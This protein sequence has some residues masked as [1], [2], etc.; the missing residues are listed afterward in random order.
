VTYKEITDKI[1]E[2]LQGDS[3]LSAEIKE[4]HFGRPLKPE[5]YPYC[6]V[7][8]DRSSIIFEAKNYTHEL[9][10]L[11]GVFDLNPKGDVAEKKVLDLS[12]RVR[13]VLRLNKLG[14]LVETSEVIA[15]ELFAFALKQ[16]ALS[17]VI[18]TYRCILFE[19]AT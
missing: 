18:S 15:H 2:T 11:I 14:N 10:F 8:F 19:S 7:T 1:I 16:F 6:F 9:Y 17:G 5:K 4:F 12:D 13:V 3:I